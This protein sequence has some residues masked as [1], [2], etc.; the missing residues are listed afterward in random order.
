MHMVIDFQFVLYAIMHVI[1]FSLILFLKILIM[2]IENLSH[3]VVEYV[4]HVQPT[5]GFNQI[6]FTGNFLA[7]LFLHILLVTTL[8]KQIRLFLPIFAR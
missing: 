4:G 5:Y 3:E 6:L 7:S 8:N 1:I 2:G